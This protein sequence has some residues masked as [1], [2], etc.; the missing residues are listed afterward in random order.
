M[1]LIP[2]F[3]LSPTFAAETNH[4]FNWLTLLRLDWCVENYLKKGSLKNWLK[5]FDTCA[6]AACILDCRPKVVNKTAQK[7]FILKFVCEPCHH[8]THRFS[9]S[10]VTSQVNTT[11]QAGSLRAGNSH[12]SLFFAFPSCSSLRFS[13]ACDCEIVAVFALS[14]VS[15]VFSLALSLARLGWF[16][17][18][19]NLKNKILLALHTRSHTHSQKFHV[20]TM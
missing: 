15:L 3:L 17:L 6:T 12:F 9:H 5:N 16:F 2:I 4:F 11:R 1:K 14:T 13:Y 7:K 8:S 10:N 20:F 18:F 19:F